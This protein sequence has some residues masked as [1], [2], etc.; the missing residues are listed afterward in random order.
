MSECKE[1][2]KLVH[3]CVSVFFFNLSTVSLDLS[4][5]MATEQLHGSSF[6]NVVKK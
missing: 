2:V 6:L 4:D 3:K 5:L 1:K